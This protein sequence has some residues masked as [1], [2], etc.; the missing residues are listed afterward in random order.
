MG[1]D[2]YVYLNVPICIKIGNID[3]RRY[4]KIGNISFREYILVCVDEHM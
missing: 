4:I 3:L 1:N 2:K